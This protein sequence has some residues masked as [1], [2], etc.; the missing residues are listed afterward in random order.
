MDESG[1]GRSQEV[2]SAEGIEVIGAVGVLV[3]SI[4]GWGGCDH[5]RTIRM[6]KAA[7][8]TI[9]PMRNL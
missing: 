4:F 2:A 8:T 9:K 6:T 3:V 1:Y 5:S 7:M